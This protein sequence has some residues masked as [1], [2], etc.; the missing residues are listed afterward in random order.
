MEREFSDTTKPSTDSPRNIDLQ[1]CSSS[2]VARQGFR[3]Y[4]T[5]Y[6]NLPI[7][8]AGPDLECLT[9]TFVCRHANLVLA[10][11]KKDDGLDPERAEPM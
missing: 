9:N 11:F 5:R 8:S 1:L 2:E 4:N 7:D 6:Y 3:A 10:V